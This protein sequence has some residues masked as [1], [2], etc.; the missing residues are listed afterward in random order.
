MDYFKVGQNDLE[1]YI[2]C[3]LE[4]SDGNTIP[5]TNYT[6]K[7]HIQRTSDVLTKTAN[8]TDG[9]GGKFEFPWESGDTSEF[10]LFRAEI[11]ITNADGKPLTMW[12]TEDEKEFYIEIHEEIG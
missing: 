6:I 7:L 2:S 8:I 11:E 4:D 5:I 12:E 10:G 1:P 9:P 3:T